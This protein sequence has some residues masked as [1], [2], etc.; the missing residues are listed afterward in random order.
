MK[1]ILSVAAVTAGLA[2]TFSATPATAAPSPDFCT[3]NPSSEFCT[4]AKI[5]LCSAYP[6]GS[7]CPPETPAQEPTQPG[8]VKVTKGSGD[9]LQDWFTNW[10]KTGELPNA[11]EIVADESWPVPDVPVI[12]R[13]VNPPSEADGEDSTPEDKQAD[14]ADDERMWWKCADMNKDTTW[15]GLLDKFLPDD[16][17]DR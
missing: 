13:P 10:T 5:E 4:P 16:R 6:G 9:Q 17:T 15:R 3:E 8:P 1:R 2:V 12:G 11:E 7:Y 14:C